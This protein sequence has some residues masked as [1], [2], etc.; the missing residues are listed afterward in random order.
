[1]A[2]HVYELEGKDGR[3]HEVATDQ[4]HDDHPPETF[5]KH[6]MDVLKGASGGVISGFILHRVHYKGRR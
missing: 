3:R 2:K 6:L 1:M 5:Q 4:H